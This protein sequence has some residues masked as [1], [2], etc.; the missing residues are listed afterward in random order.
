MAYKDYSNDE[1]VTLGEIMVNSRGTEEIRV[2]RVV[3][4]GDVYYDV[5]RWYIDI[6]DNFKPTQ[7]G[8]RLSKEMTK[9][10]LKILNHELDGG[11]SGDEDT[12]YST[13]KTTGGGAVSGASGEL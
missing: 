10:I 4:D 6:S 13:D 1:R 3:S 12:E 8:V 7:K 11:E 2:D 9:A 5:R